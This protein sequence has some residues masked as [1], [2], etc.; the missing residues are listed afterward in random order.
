M[1]VTLIATYK[2]LRESNETYNYTSIGCHIGY[3]VYVVIHPT[4]TF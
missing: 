4:L 3:N 1:T 2:S